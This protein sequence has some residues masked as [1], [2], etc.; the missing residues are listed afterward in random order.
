MKSN[1]ASLARWYQLAELSHKVKKSELADVAGNVLSLEVAMDE[2][3]RDLQK[4]L[5]ER[6]GSEWLL[7]LVINREGYLNPHLV[8]GICERFIRTTHMRT[9]V[10]LLDIDNGSKG[11]TGPC[12]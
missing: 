11:H 5:L 3:E 2:K 4:T 7:C 6:V 9:F 1:F 8:R 12:R 10:L